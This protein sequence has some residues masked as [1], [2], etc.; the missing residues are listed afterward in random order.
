MILVRVVCAD[1]VLRSRSVV[2]VC[3]V[4]RSIDVEMGIGVSA[5]QSNREA[6]LN[7]RLNRSVTKQHHVGSI[8]TVET[9]RAIRRSSAP[10]CVRTGALARRRF[11]S[12]SLSQIDFRG[13]GVGSIQHHRMPDDAAERGMARVRQTARRLLL[14]GGLTQ[15]NL[16]QFMGRESIVQSADDRFADAGLADD[17]NGLQWMGEAP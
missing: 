15:P 11:G 4:C 16:D 1:T 8:S 12:R 14:V 17:D 5:E 2:P 6:E 3:V 10:L 7:Q 13:L 9:L